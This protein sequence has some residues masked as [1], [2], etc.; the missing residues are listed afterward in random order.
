MALHRR[1]LLRLAALLLALG[2]VGLLAGCATTPQTTISPRSD[3]AGHVQGLYKL[4]FIMAVVVFVVVE[5]LLVYAIIRF[6]RRQPPNGLPPQVHGNQRLEIAWTIL[7]VVVLIIIAVPTWQVIF[8][9]HAAAPP[10]ALRVNVTGH[11][12]WWEIEYP[13]LGITTANEL[14]LPAGR[15]VELSLESNDVLHSFWVPQLAGK[16]DMLPGNVNHLRFTP[17]TPGTYLGQ[18][19]EFCGISHANMRLRATVHEPADFEAWVRGQQEPAAEPTGLAAE[20]Q[21]VFLRQCRGCHTVEGT[22]ARG[23]L[24]PNLTHVASRETIAAGLLPNT[25][26]GLAA[27]LR[28]PP[29]VKPGAKMPNLRLDEGQVQ[30]LVAYL[31][32]LE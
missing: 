22:D 26:E 7:P 32:T 5:G 20:G 30:A 17:S 23:R 2:A 10:D 29:E 13:D 6:S 8:S 15:P 27:W 1:T 19:A 18:C 12:W 16:M 14:H 31:Q 3:V 25:P 28:N 21:Q 11:Q 24:G 4:I 9:T